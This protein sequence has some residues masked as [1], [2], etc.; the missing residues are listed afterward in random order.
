MPS[1]LHPLIA[2]AWNAHS[3]WLQWTPDPEARDGYRVEIAVRERPGDPAAWQLIDAGRVRRHWMVIPVW[4]S[5]AMVQA[6]VSAN[7]SGIE[8]EPALECIFKRSRCVFCFQAGAQPLHFPPGASFHAPVDGLGCSYSTRL[9]IDVPAHE[10]VRATLW[11]QCSGGF[12]Q[13]DEPGDFELRAG[14]GARIWN[15]EASVEDVEMTGRDYTVLQAVPR[16]GPVS[17]VKL[18]RNPSVR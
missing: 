13:L 4:R 5:G 7:G 1:L 18:P 11:A 2:G 8:A 9:D 14:P 6:R 10:T 3:L 15:A 12:S 16:D 17:I